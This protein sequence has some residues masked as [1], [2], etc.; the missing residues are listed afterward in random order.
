VVDSEGEGHVSSS[1]W[2]GSNKGQALSLD[3]GTGEAE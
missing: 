1:R 3:G 2:T